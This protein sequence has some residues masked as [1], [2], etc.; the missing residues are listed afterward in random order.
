M[1]VRI[2]KAMIFLFLGAVL[3]GYFFLIHGDPFAATGSRYNRTPI[4]GV[5]VGAISIL[6]GIALLLDIDP[7]VDVLLQSEEE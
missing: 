7:V 4:Y 6:L 3:L 1:K 5:T 2:R